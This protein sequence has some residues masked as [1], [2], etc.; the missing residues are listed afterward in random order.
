[1]TNHITKRQLAEKMSVTP[2]TVNSWMAKRL[3]PFVRVGHITRFD[4]AAVEAAF[5]LRFTVPA[6]DG[7]QPQRRRMERQNATHLRG[8]Q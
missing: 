5:L 3:I 7:T 8:S 4:P 2:R 1:M 6:K